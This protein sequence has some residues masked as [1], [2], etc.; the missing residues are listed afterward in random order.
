MTYAQILRD[1]DVTLTA[2]A[3][4]ATVARE[5]MPRRRAEQCARALTAIGVEASAAPDHEDRDQ[6][7]LYVTV[8]A[9]AQ[10]QGE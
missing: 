8:P 7:W 1:Y 6:A 5:A 2:D 9:D 10:A 3:E 4:G